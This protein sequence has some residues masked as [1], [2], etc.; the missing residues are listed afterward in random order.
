MLRLVEPISLI[1]RLVNGKIAS[2]KRA[3]KTVSRLKEI[4]VVRSNTF[5][6]MSRSSSSNAQNRFY[7]EF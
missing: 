2:L 1:G 5:S 7:T 4:K 6:M 3:L